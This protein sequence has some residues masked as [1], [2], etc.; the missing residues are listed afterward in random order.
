MVVVLMIVAYILGSIPNALWIGKVFKGIDVR[1]HGSKNTGS[2]NAARV[3]GA[4]LGILTLILDISKGAIPT[5]IATMLLES[6][7]SVI[8]VGICAI[9]GHS[10]SIFM[11]FKG[12]KAVA[13][14]V[15]VFIVLVP[16]AIL[17]AAVIFFL[18]FGITRYVSLSSM[19]GAISLPI[20]IILFYK[21]IPLTIFGIIIAILIIVRHKSNIQ[22]LLNGTESKFSINKKK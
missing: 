15:G 1:E 12:G 22:R 20:W 21:N 11:K 9:L 19:I 7:I 3:L 5:L 8:L 2:T 14:T 17:L 6:S 4:K 16:G 10:F 13:T 18:V